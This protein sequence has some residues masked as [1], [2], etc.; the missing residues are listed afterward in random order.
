MDERID[1]KDHDIVV[2]VQGQNVAV[3]A[4][5]IKQPDVQ[6]MKLHYTA[7]DGLQW[8]IAKSNGRSGDKC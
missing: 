4:G 6:E 7:A 3:Y 5:G 1:A 8:F 2:T